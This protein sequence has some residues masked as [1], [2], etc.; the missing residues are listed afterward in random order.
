MTK[1][2]KL[3]L[4]L[5]LL[6]GLTSLALLAA[7]AGSL[8]WYAFSRTVSVTFVG[9]SVATSSLLNIGL[10]D[11]SEG[12]PYFSDE[13]LV[14]YSLE[15]E[16]ATEGTETKVIYWSR[17]RSGISLL[18]LRHYLEQ[19]PYAV[20]KLHPVT[21]GSMEALNDTDDFKLF[22]S[23]EVSETEFNHEAALESYSVLPFAFRIIDEN[24]QYVANKNVWLTAASIDAENDVENSVR[25][26]A[27]G[28]NKL[29]IKPADQANHIGETKVGG[30]L[31]LGPSE[32]YDYDGD[33]K[34]YCY[35]EFE[36]EK[37]LITYNSLEDSEYNVLSNIND[38]EN[39][40]EQTTFYAKHHNGVLVPDI[41]SA[42]PKVQ[43]HYG[44]GKVKPS[45]HSNGEF[46]IDTTN[47]NGVPIATTS[48]GSKIAYATFTIFVEGWD[49]S[50]IDQNA[51]YSFNLGLKFEID[52]I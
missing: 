5:S 27:D 1:E 49:H 6:A 11:T 33:N 3:S 16:E 2:K 45:S 19:S 43:E 52:R 14:A 39:P 12:E 29:L 24:S 25:V 26:F 23:P 7:T 20:D 32:F 22:R 4:R 28:A 50:I 18:A 8:A 34:E 41:D 30:V 10:V 42:V 15:R 31:S 35:G 44:I 46:Y 17:S 13:D 38:V 9:T 51:G 21:T 48:N 47:G 40:S 36:T 37:S